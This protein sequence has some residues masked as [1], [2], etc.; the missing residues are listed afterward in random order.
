[1]PRLE[2]VVTKKLC[3]FDIN[4]ENWNYIC[5]VIECVNKLIFLT[6]VLLEVKN[7]Q[8]GETVTCD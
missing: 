3:L 2:I 1:M 4:R 5:P 6:V 7:R 8:I